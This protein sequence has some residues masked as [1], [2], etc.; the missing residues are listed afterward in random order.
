MEVSN[1]ERW[2][3]KKNRKKP[4]HQ[5]EPIFLRSGNGYKII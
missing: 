5:M 2:V 3:E 1:V 4:Q